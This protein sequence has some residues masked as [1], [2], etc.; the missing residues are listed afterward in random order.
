M[1]DAYLPQ[2]D[3]LL[4]YYLLYVSAVQECLLVHHIY[5]LNRLDR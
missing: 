5:S 3:G 2:H 4:P 1:F